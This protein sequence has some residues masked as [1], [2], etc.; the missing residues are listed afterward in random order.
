MTPRC[1]ISAQVLPENAV[2]HGHLQLYRCNAK[3]PHQCLDI[4]RFMGQ[5]QFETPTGQV[6]FCVLLCQP[7]LCT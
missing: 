3:N 5:G 4:W 7:L 6:N 2:K 1:N